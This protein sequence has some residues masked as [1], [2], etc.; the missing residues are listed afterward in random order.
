[1][2][3]PENPE[4]LSGL[5]ETFSRP[6]RT[7]SQAEI[8]TCVDWLFDD[9]FKYLMLFILHR[10]GDWAELTDAMDAWSSFCAPGLLSVI[11]HYDPMRGRGFFSYLLFCLK[12]H[13]N[14]Y[15]AD[16]LTTR[17]RELPLVFSSD[18]E[19]W[20][21]QLEDPMPGMTIEQLMEIRD[22][23]QNAINSLR[24]HVA[25]VVV[26]YYLQGESIAEI[27]GRM[28]VPASTIRT[29]L[30][31]ARKDMKRMLTELRRQGRSRHER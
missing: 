1:M 26:N 23:L 24:P 13:C 21:L 22:Q 27:A 7:W 16:V 28:K 30:F 11:E 4:G 12:R 20:E 29:W 14:R 18:G 19:E 3:A 5:E 17:D 25:D 15:T 2:L 10:L 6:G 8:T 31:R 9:K